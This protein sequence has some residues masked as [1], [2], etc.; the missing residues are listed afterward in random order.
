[1]STFDISTDA[2][3]LLRAESANITIQLDRTSQTTARISWNIPSPAA[4]CGAESRAYDG[5][6]VTVDTS[7]TNASKV[8]VQGSSYGGDQTIDANLFAGDRVGSAMVVGAFY[9]DVTTTFVDIDGL[10]VGVPYYVTGFPVDAQYRYFIEGVHAYSQDNTNR[11]SEDT[12]GTQVL[13]LNPMANVMGVAPTDLTGLDPLVTYDFKIQ[14]GLSPKP[15]AAPDSVDCVPHAPVYTI[16]IPGSAAL[17][18]QDMVDAINYQL[19]I[20]GGVQQSPVAPSTGTYYWN[21]QIGKLFTWTGS[22]HIELSVIVQPTSPSIVAVG[23]YWYNPTTDI[24]QL[25]DGTTFAPVTVVQSDTDPAAPSMGSYWFNGTTVYQWNGLTWCPTS[26]TI[27]ITDPSSPPEPVAGSFWYNPDKEVLMRWNDTTGMW[28]PS[29]A[30]QYHVNPNAL[31]VGTAWFN[32]STNVLSVF[33]SPAAGWNVQTNVAV[34]ENAPTTPSPGKYWFNPATQVLKRWNGVGMVWDTV[35]VLVFPSDPTVRSFCDVWWNTFNGTLHVWNGISSA[36]VQVPTLYNQA[37]DPTELIKFTLGDMW[38][39]PTTK[40]LYEWNGYCFVPVAFVSMATDPTST[41]LPGTVWVNHAKTAW[42]VRSAISTWTP[43]LPT[44]STTDIRTLPTATMW[45]DTS[46]NALNTWN[47]IAWINL[48]YVTAPVQPTKN[49]LWYDLTNHV[50]KMWNGDN[51]VVGTPKATC[52]MDC[53]GNI[54]FTDTRVG[55]QSF[56][57]LTAGTLFE[58]LATPNTYHTPKPGQDGSSD[59]PS[60]AE[61]GIGTDG[62]DAARRQ[63][64]NEIRYELGYPVID[65][66]LTPEQMDYIIDKTLSEL[67]ARAGVAYKRGFFFMTIASEQQVYLL[68][69]KVSK[70]NTIVDILGVYRCT[71]AFLSSAHASGVY[72]QIM[73][74]HLY[75]MGSFDLLSFY[76]MSEYTKLMEMLFAARITFSWNEQKREL[77]IHHRFPMSERMVCIEASTE[78]TEQDLLTDRYT[79]AWIRRY[80]LATARLILAETRGKFSSLPGASGAVT[81]NAAELRQA[82]KDEIEA[83]LLEIEE[84][85]VDKPDEYGIGCQFTFG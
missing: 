68:T 6:L 37:T 35:D 44:V 33:G 52:E 83:C 65:V 80:S 1:M 12:H 21:A 31:T 56:V 59:T 19:S 9:N 23:T 30:V 49:A 61:V 55:S 38:Y 46:T 8:P 50:L 76:A 29:D 26:L 22:K 18:Y 4:G 32:E 72:G 63:M 84:Y 79:R 69:N 27:N 67:R 28:N 85:V 82:A 34:V 40:S 11:G 13:V 39:R 51:W 2:P 70:M 58:G 66:E 41:I 3:G 75:N 36:W 77:F 43:I 42:F 54:L 73:M 74:Q 10:K 71:S 7:P 20:L 14:V 24:L 62:S 5:M 16:T 78:R 64:Q 15:Q 17:T 57:Q 60:Y 45:F 81:L 47:G 48:S 25:Y 53:H